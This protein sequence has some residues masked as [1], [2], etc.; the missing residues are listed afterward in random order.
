MTDITKVREY[1]QF[2]IDNTSN[3]EELRIALLI[4]ERIPNIDKPADIPAWVVDK[5]FRSYD[6]DTMLN[7]SLDEILYSINGDLGTL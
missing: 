5:I 7:D 3:M 6:R 2:L 4:Y 1:F